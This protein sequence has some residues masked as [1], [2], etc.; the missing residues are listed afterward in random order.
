MK[1][2]KVYIAILFLLSC[3]PRA[4]QG[5]NRNWQT[6]N[7]QYNIKMY[8]GDTCVFDDNFYGIIN[9]EENSD[10]IYY[11]KG[12]TLIEIGGNYVIKSDK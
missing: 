11:F 5:C 12:D 6:S 7:R 9:Q 4:R 2:I 1:S 3:T 8:S 10:G